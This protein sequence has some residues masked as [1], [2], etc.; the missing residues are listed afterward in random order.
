M[1]PSRGQMEDD[2]LQLGHLLNA[3]AWALLAESGLL[4]AAVGDAVGPPLRSPVD[5]QVAGLDLA[6]ELPGPV[7]VLGEDAGSQSVVGVV[8]QGNRFVD[9]V[10]RSDGDG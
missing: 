1:A 9:V 3:V 4:E 5:V 2:H 7:D 10:E 8:G 6:G